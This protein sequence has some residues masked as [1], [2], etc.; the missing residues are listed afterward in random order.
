MGWPFRAALAGCDDGAGE[1]DGEDAAHERQATHSGKGATGVGGARP[2]GSGLLG[3]ADR[4]AALDGR[5]RVDSPADG[6]TPVAADIPLAE[7]ESGAEGH[8][9]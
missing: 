1:D 5:L 9:P 8:S 2:G 7:K 4:V 6:G 3:L